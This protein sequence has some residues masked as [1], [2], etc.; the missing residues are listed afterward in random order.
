MRLTFLG[1]GPL[2][3]GM[4]AKGLV[5]V[6]QLDVPTP[7]WM[8]ELDLMTQFRAMAG[9]PPPEW[10]NPAREWIEANPAEWQALQNLHA[11]ARASREEFRRSR[12]GLGWPS[13]AGSRLADV[14]AAAAAGWADSD[15]LMGFEP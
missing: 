3:A 14:P 4:V 6:E 5:T 15:D 7:R 8:A 13:S 2:L 12:S 11:D 1:V 10:R 9:K